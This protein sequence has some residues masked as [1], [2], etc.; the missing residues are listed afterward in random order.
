MQNLE[1]ITA[2]Q[3]GLN[4]YVTVDVA[5]V[6][7]FP[8]LINQLEIVNSQLED[9]VSSLV[10]GFSLLAKSLNLVNTVL[11]GQ[12]FSDSG[13]P[14]ESASAGEHSFERKLE[15]I[16]RF[17]DD[18]LEV[19][20]SIHVSATTEAV[21]QVLSDAGKAQT[22]HVQRIILRTL[23]MQQLASEIGAQAA[24][25]VNDIKIMSGAVS[26][27]DHPEKV[28]LQ[29]LFMEMQMEVNKMV[30]AFQFQDRVSQ[31][32]SA[33]MNSMKDL[34]DYIREAGAQARLDETDVYV[35]LAEIMNRVEKYYV[36]K[37]QYEM[38]GESNSQ[39]SDDIILF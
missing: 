11:N 39:G 9:G 28:Q 12:S 29:N 32:I 33:V 27:S 15:R 36:S 24:G 34:L 1:K 20:E 26:N 38:T 31:I 22:K 35:N 2:T 13:Q 7:V 21:Q 37:E 30:I 23:N 25:V 5:C 10:S 17:S 8:L 4:N 3:A 16:K 19:G 6:S 14:I 18:L